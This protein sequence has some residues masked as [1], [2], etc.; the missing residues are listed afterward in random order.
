MIRKAVRPS[1]PARVFRAL[2]IFGKALPSTLSP[3]D[4]RALWFRITESFAGAWQ[5]SI[6]ID[7]DT[8]D[9]YWAVF[10]CI[11]LI[12]GDIAKLPARVMQYD[13]TD[14]IWKPTQ[15]RQVLRQP[16]NYQT[17]VEFFAHWITS[18]L[19]TGNTYVLKVRDPATTFVT[20]LYIL[21]PAR[22]TP[23][24]STDGGVYYRLADDALSGLDKGSVVVPQSEIIHDRMYTLYHPLVGV[25]P[26][27]ACGVGAM[28]G[29]AI[30]NNS[31]MFFRNMSRPSGLLT[32]P[33]EIGTDVATRLKEYWDTNFTGEKAGK[34]AVLG[35]GLTY[36]PMSTTPDDAQLI[37]QL[38][39]TA[40]MVCACFHVPPYKLGLGDMPTVNNVAALNQQYYD[41][42]LQFLIE[43]MEARLDNGLE[44]D[45]TNM[46]VWFDLSPLLRMDP[47]TRMTVKG[48]Q[49]KDGWLSPNEARRDEE[50]PPVDGGD[51]P[52]LQQQNFSLAALAKR[53]A[54][55]NPFAT[56]APAA[57][58]AMPSAD[59]QART[60]KA[61]ALLEI[62]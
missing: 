45:G 33:G 6:T 53:D 41:Q 60:F 49:I 57:P 7:Y 26:L 51:T 38:K 10:S 15:Q 29:A 8:V 28:Q 59:A 43:K 3:V 44:L 39:M 16:N 11:T 9:A 25:S 27:F 47:Q 24:V 31:A 42:C 34:V 50:L 13:P 5:Q 17:S 35:D 4:D 12:T 2:R 36:A 54:Q 37:E 14:K 62:A 20:K 1:L 18:L 21:D 55:D 61:L 19:R 32:A 52:Y 48:Q 46:Q 23:L 40:E 58:V 56:S 30:L 22:V